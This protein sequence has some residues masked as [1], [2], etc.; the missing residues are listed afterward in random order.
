M[1]GYRLLCF[2]RFTKDKIAIVQTSLDEAR[3]EGSMLFKKLHRL[4]PENRFHSR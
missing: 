2:L 1:N 3:G 4:H